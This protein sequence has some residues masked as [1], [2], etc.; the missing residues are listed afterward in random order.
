MLRRERAMR[1]AFR[2]GVQGRPGSPR[3]KP[4]GSSVRLR[5][6]L[7]RWARVSLL[8]SAPEPARPLMNA[9]RCRPEPSAWPLA[10]ALRAPHSATCHVAAT[11]IAPLLDRPSG[12]NLA[13]AGRPA[14][15]AWPMRA[16]RPTWRSGTT[17]GRWW[18]ETRRVSYLVH[19]PANYA[20]TSP[21][22][23]V[24]DFHPL[25]ELRRWQPIAP[26]TASW[27]SKQDSSWPGRRASTKPGTSARVARRRARSTT[28]GSRGP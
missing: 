4:D 18:S 16:R 24:L 27:A 15:E 14:T 19:L 12:A 7:R 2:G 21:V 13:S 17:T 23:L 1:G 11:P 10:R 9:R 8:A 5:D 28:L 25:A 6:E 22:P 20:G 3:R 26:G